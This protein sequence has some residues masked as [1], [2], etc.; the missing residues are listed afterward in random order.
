MN[1][2]SDETFIVSPTSGEVHAWQYA[3]A[4]CSGLLIYQ[5]RE[6]ALSASTKWMALRTQ[7]QA[8]EIECN[9]LNSMIVHNAKL[10][11]VYRTDPVW[12]RDD[13]D[14][15]NVAHD[16]AVIARRHQQALEQIDA[17]TDKLVVAENELVELIRQ[18]DLLTYADHEAVDG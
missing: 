10:R 14:D 18:Q 11:R 12:E 8:K 6:D 15:D 2:N 17:C 9:R 16:Q 4:V 1:D 5:S 3:E 13:V 7:I